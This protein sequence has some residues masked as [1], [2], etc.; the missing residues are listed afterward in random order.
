MERS[1]A[2]TLRFLERLPERA[3]LEP[4]TQGKWSLKDTFAHI[5]AWEEE[6]VRRL[7]LIEC[8]RG[9]RI[10]FYNDMRE[11]DR[12]NARAV[13]RARPWSWKALLGRA[14]RVRRRLIT[15]LLQVPPAE[16]HNPSH[17]YPVTVWLPEFAWT[18]EQG[19]LARIRAWRR[20][21]RRR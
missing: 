5:V 6:A 3:V 8:G 1:R 4:H 15:A 21:N 17:R 18:H 2:A 10:H 11:A 19:H 9:D 16:L 7:A 20:K 12:F 13:R 14:A